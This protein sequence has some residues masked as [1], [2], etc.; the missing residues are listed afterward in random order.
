MPGALSSL[1]ILDFS[2]LLPG[3]FATMFLA[4]L[5]ADIIRVEAPHRPDYLRLAPPKDKGTS[6]GHSL[7]NR[8]KRS[9]ALNLKTPEAVRI[10]KR[11]VKTYDIV[12]EQ[13]RPG[14]MDRLGIGYESLKT[15]NPRLIYCALTGYGQTGPYRDRAGHDINYLALSGAASHLGRKDEG[16]LP[17]S[18]QIADVGAGSYNVMVGIL[19][20]E[21]H[22]RETG[23]GQFIDIS[24]FDGSV[25]WNNLAFAYYF[26]T[27]ENPQREGALLNGGSFYDYYQTNDGRYLSIGSL[28]PKFWKGFC[29]AIGRPDLAT[30]VSILNPKSYLKV[31][32]EIQKVIAT[33][34]LSDWKEIFDSANVCVEPVLDVSETEKHPQTQARNIIVEVPRKDGSSQKQVA[35]PIKFS[36]C[37]T[38]YKH[39]GVKLGEHTIEILKEAGYS[40]SEINAFKKAGAIAEKPNK[41]NMIL[42]F[43]KS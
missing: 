37:A 10:A 35:N 42:N 13:F 20:A 16:P 3:P 39:T 22:R 6:I 26:G 29:A 8:S 7:L 38:E 4:D 18:F 31:K 5:G 2:T 23:K 33:R 12:V 1:K 28:E 40:Q 27:G 9:I 30:E 41:L 21:I 32:P 43:I 19:A 36:E 24:M 25:T 14:V 15:V 34:S 11:L 17:L